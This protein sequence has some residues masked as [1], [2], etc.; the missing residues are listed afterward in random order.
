MLELQFLCR[1]LL[2]VVDIDHSP[3]F[4][5]DCRLQAGRCNR[6]PIHFAGRDQLAGHAACH[7]T[8]DRGNHFTYLASG[9]R[10]TQNITD[11]LAGLEGCTGTNGC[12]GQAGPAEILLLATDDA[13]ALGN[14]IALDSFDDAAQQTATTAETR[15]GADTG[16]DTASD[17]RGNKGLEREAMLNTEHVAD[18]LFF[19]I[20]DRSV[21]QTIDHRIDQRLGNC[22]RRVNRRSSGGNCSGARYAS[23]GCDGTCGDGGCASAGAGGTGSNRAV[24]SQ[25]FRLKINRSI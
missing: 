20:A 18:G 8:A 11:C 19:Q 12:T 10:F 3:G 21:F 17:G 24:T 4:T 14:D 6:S 2:C 16:S 13:H 22:S 5:V 15:D 25:D 9:Q 23:I 1:Q 7:G